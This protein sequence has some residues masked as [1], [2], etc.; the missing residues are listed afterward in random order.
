MFK[1]SCGLV[2]SASFCANKVS[3]AIIIL[4]VVKSSSQSIKIR[5][6]SVGYKISLLIALSLK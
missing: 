4:A 5:T 6:Q 2:L 1:L 3:T